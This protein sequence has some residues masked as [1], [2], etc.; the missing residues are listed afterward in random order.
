LSTAV[1]CIAVPTGFVA[2]TSHTMDPLSVTASIIAILQLSMKVGECLSDAKDASTERSQ[3]TT[4]TSNLSHL[5]VTLLSRID[6]SSNDPWH[7]KVRELGGKDGLIYQYRVAL[8]QLKDKISSGH[9]LKKMA[10]TLLWKYIKG[11][12]ERILLRIERLK[13]LLHITLEMDHLFVSL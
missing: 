9:G 12:V 1:S 8:E 7:T 6:E 3:F 11:D 10:K 4:E 2:E 5:L 13:S